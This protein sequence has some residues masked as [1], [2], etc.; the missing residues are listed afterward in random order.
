MKRSF[1]W[2]PLLSGFL[3]VLVPGLIG[4]ALAG[5]WGWLAGVIIGLALV[6]VIGCIRWGPPWAKQ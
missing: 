1:R 3:F 2:G 5:W 6:F 4:K